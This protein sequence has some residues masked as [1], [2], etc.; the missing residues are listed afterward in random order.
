MRLW[1]KRSGKELFAFH[2]L[3]C[4]VLTVAFCH[5]G[6]L[7]ATAGESGAI[8]IYSIERIE[9]DALRRMQDGDAAAAAQR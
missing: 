8:V 9:V 2:E 1:A 3:R 6:S 5:D 7:L 4:P